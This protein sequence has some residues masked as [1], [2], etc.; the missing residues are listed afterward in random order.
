MSTVI[1]LTAVLLLSAS[2]AQE[3]A[4]PTWQLDFPPQDSQIVSMLAR[5]S[6]AADA[7]ERLRRAPVD[8]ETVRALLRA[9][10][11]AGLLQSLRIIVDDHPDRMA[12]AFEEIEDRLYEFRGDT[13]QKRRHADTLQQIVADARRRLDTLPRDV[14]AR[15]ERAFL[16]IDSNFSRDRN[17]WMR[18]LREF[19]QRYRGTEAALLAEVDVIAAQGATPRMIE[20]L[21]AFAARHPGTTAAAK[22]IY[23]KGFQYHTGNMLEY[24]ARGADPIQRFE[25]VEAVVREL[26]SG[27]YPE[28]E[29]TSKAPSLIGQFYIPRDATIPR[30]SLE[31]L[32]GAFEAFARAHFDAALTVRDRGVVDYVI[33]SK[34]PDLY[35]Q[36]EDRTTGFER[37]LATL[38]GSAEVRAAVRQLQGSYYLRVTDR[39]TAEQRQARLEK[40]KTAFRAAANES[41]SV[42][43]RRSLAT[44]ASIEFGDGDCTAALKTLREYLDRHS[45]T[46]W[47]WVALIRAGQCEE[48]LGNTESA[49]DYFR[50]AARTG[51]SVPP[52]R[53]LGHAYAGR[54]LETTG[55]IRSARDEYVRA[56]D[57][58]DNRY[59]QSYSTYVSRRP[60]PSDPFSIAPD[61]AVVTK[62]WLIERGAR[63]T[64]ALATPGGDLIEQARAL[65]TRGDLEQAEVIAGRFLTKHP[66]SDLA[67]EARS[68]AHLARLERA[69][70]LANTERPGNNPARAAEMLDAL[71]REPLDF[72]VTAARIARATLRWMRGDDVEE[73][74]GELKAALADWHA[75]Q[76]LREPAQGIE[77]DIAEIRR[78]VFLPRGGGIYGADR[79]NAFEWSEASTPFYILNADLRVKLHDEEIRQFTMAHRL[80]DADNAVFLDTAQIDLL[81]KIIVSLGGT[82]RAEPAHIMQTPNQPVGGARQIVTL[83][84]RFF[85]ARPG[86]WGGWELE[87]YPVITEI[88]FTNA[89]RTKASVRVTIG[90]SGGTVELEKEGGRWIARRLVGLWIT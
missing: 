34:L 35:A 80:P 13:E 8:I 86:H 84:K 39:E 64:Q 32:I 61:T 50:R 54:V 7:E 40:A 14:A 45:D 21:D 41:D 57:G 75:R 53:V 9:Q 28:S 59:G 44:L 20:A 76:Q 55:A 4:V 81:K 56:L 23:Q 15:A 90:Y 69:L 47:T 29:W 88:H 67:A 18:S 83:W 68:I 3:Q 52:A 38:D 60:N 19:T 58:W 2:A 26:L 70:A 65:L 16:T 72:A 43:S 87:T 77:Q 62:A 31:R 63:L 10:D 25:R 46:P 27:R 51:T 82:K 5:T 12:A 37:F 6:D 66:Q 1:A 89:E 30:D 49:V 73:M 85:P 24:E 36:R 74:E 79:W 17:D 11:Y 71:V 22:A 78:A 48:A 42:H 33:T